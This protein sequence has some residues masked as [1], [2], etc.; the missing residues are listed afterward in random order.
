MG[1]VLWVQCPWDPS[2]WL[3]VSMSFSLSCRVEIPDVDGPQFVIFNCRRTSRWFPVWGSH[4]WSWYEPLLDTFLCEC[5]SITLGKMPRN[6]KWL[7]VHSL[8]KLPNYFPECCTILHSHCPEK[9]LL[10]GSLKKNFFFGLFRATPTACESSQARGW[11]RAGAAGLY[12]SHSN[13]GSE[14]HLWPTLPYD[15]H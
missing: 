10:A 1:F 14:P 12:H 6:A 2:W 5:I 15:L 9:Q 13:K 8:K 4:G 7:H 3:W 11:I